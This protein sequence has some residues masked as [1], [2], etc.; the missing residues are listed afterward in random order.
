[1]KE[2]S[3][4]GR[5]PIEGAPIHPA[6]RESQHFIEEQLSI[7]QQKIAD[8]QE[9]I[10][11]LKALGVTTEPQEIDLQRLLA[12]KTELESQLR[13]QPQTELYFKS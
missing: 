7:V 3:P 9:T 11:N 13:K 5:Q 8:K 2:K 4:E 10:V 1:M 12:R 6:E